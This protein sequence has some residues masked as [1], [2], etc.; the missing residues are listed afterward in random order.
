[1]S[2]SAITKKALADSLKSLCVQKAF[3][4][5]SISDI[6]N[7]CGLNRQSFYYHFQDKYELLSWVYYNELF[8]HYSNGIGFVNWSDRLEELLQTMYKNRSFYT[9]TLKMRR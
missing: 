1:M 8:K 6:T 3:D 2:S 5:I 4:K 7:N 9:S